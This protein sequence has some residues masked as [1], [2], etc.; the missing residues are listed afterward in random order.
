MK[1]YISILLAIPLTLAGC[2]S[3]ATPEEK[4]EIKDVSV[5]APTAAYS[6]E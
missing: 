6:L 1:K 4:K 2:S 3:S 5:N